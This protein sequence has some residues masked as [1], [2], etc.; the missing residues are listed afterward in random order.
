M[1]VP[2]SSTERRSRVKRLIG[3][4]LFTLWVVAYAATLVYGA[5]L[6]IGWNILLFAGQ[7]SRES[8]TI[9]CAD[10]VVLMYLVLWWGSGSPW[11]FGKPDKKK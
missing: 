6:L 2:D 9:V 4:G 1:K 5:F 10:A 7:A 8:F 3:N 11:N